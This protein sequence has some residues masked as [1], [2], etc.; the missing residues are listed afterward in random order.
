MAQTTSAVNACDVVVQLDDA[1]GTLT[2]IS[3]SSNQA[4][5]NLSAN[6]AETYTFSGDFAIKKSC[7]KAVSISL[8]VLYTT[9]D[10][11]GSNILLDWY[12]N[13][14]NTSRS[15]QID[16][17]NSNAGSE[18]YAGEVILESLSVPLTAD[19]AGII[20]VSASLSN[21]GAFTRSII[22]S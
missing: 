8:S 12:F 14:L 7:K 4:S 13:S 6:T 2:D 21:D 3:G 19:D 18:R 11:E 17:P 10:A 1:D 15:I 22:S 5:I 16:V 20:I 9:E